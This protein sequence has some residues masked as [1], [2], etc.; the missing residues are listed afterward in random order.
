MTCRVPNKN[1][2]VNKEIV[3]V[4]NWDWQGHPNP[5]PISSYKKKIG[6]NQKYLKLCLCFLI[7]VFRLHVNRLNMWYYR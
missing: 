6:F 4:D 7:Y 3:L 2:S 1:S 5:K